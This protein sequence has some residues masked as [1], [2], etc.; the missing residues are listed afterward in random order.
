MMLLNVGGPT[1]TIQF[2]VC[3]IS[4]DALDGSDG[5]ANGRAGWVRN[6]TAAR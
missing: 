5:S 2:I 4:I 6:A 1:S 3:V